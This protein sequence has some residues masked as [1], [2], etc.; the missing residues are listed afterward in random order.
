MRERSVLVFATTIIFYL[1]LDIQRILYLMIRGISSQ[2]KLVLIVLFAMLVGAKI[3]S[4]IG[5]SKTPI[6]FRQD[7]HASGLLEALDENFSRL[8]ALLDDRVND[9]NDRLDYVY[10]RGYANDND[11]A[12]I[13][14]ALPGH[15]QFQWHQREQPVQ[16]RH[17]QDQHPIP[18]RTKSTRRVSETLKK[19][20]AHNQ[21]YTCAMCRNM[22]PP[23][24]Q[25]DHIVPLYTDV[26][27]THSDYLNSAQN[28]QALCPNCHSVKTQHDLIRYK[29]V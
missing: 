14:H 17:R 7:W 24:Y 12:D 29:T 1:I 21:R 15:R 3:A 16:Q 10:G 25:V 27:G 23:S 2:L 20:V 9:E 26:Y 18:T 19:I 6:M 5:P 11:Y 28:L 8:D 4:Y 13:R 22:L